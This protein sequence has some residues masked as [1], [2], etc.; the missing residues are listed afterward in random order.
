LGGGF[1]FFFFCFLGVFFGVFGLLGFFF[2]GVLTGVK[3]SFTDP[4][5]LFHPHYS[6]TATPQTTFTHWFLFSPQ[7]FS[8]RVVGSFLNPTRARVCAFSEQTYF[9]VSTLACV[10]PPTGPPLL[11]QPLT[12]SPPIAFPPSLVISRD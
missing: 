4:S 11:L 3:V 9:E 5:P 2:F 7:V 10:V 12:E 1:F 6:F 8:G